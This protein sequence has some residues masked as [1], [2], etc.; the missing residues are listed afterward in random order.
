MKRIPRLVAVIELLLQYHPKALRILVGEY[1]PDLMELSEI[2]QAASEV[3]EN[4]P[5]ASGLPKSKQL[6]NIVRGESIQ[7]VIDEVGGWEHLSEAVRLYRDNFPKT[8][9][10][11][12]DHVFSV[13]PGR[14]TRLE[15]QTQL[16]RIADKHG[17]C[18]ATI[19]EKRKIVP[20]AIARYAEMAPR[21][22]LRLLADGPIR[23]EDAERAR[24]EIFDTAREQGTLPWEK[25]D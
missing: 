20:E 10:I 11:F 14:A 22:E 7:S 18:I 21:G 1:V 2:V 12:V 24:Q 19:C 3:E 6:A 17:F 23:A 16:K 13:E 5:N 15:E 9:A 8:W 4:A 25:E